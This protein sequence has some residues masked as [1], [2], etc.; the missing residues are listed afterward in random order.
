M[1]SGD[2]DPNFCQGKQ[3]RDEAAAGRLLSSVH[4]RDILGK[5]PFRGK[6]SML[7]TGLRLQGLRTP[8][9]QK[10]SYFR[11]LRAL[12]TVDISSERQEETKSKK[13][14]RVK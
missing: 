8:E 4:K 10:R 1:V 2:S 7:C 14:K 5:G 6:L 3:G 13:G 9:R 11:L 12:S